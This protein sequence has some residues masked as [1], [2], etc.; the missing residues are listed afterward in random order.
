MTARLILICSAPPLTTHFPDNGEASPRFLQKLAPMNLPTDTLCLT[1]SLLRAE[2]TC[3]ALGLRAQIDPA[4]DELD[5]GEW[6]GRDPQAVLAEDPSAFAGWL[7]DPSVAPP[8]G[9]SFAQVADRVEGLL[10]RPHLT[11]LNGTVVAISHPGP[12]QAAI[13]KVLNA[14]LNV[15][16]RI[17]IKPGSQTQLS[18]DGKRWS[19]TV[20]CPLSQSGAR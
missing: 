8:G 17:A 3:L 12:I 9:E 2:Q 20:G 14:P 4:L 5:F 6:K 7:A 16:S 18:H 19:L 15:A 1:S 13:L 10:Q 11:Q